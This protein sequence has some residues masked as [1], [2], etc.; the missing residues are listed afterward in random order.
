MILLQKSIL[1]YNST[2][3]KNAYSSKDVLKCASHTK[4]LFQGN[5]DSRPSDDSDSYHSTS[6][7]IQSE[8]FNAV[9]ANNSFPQGFPVLGKGRSSTVYG[10]SPKYVFKLPVRHNDLS[11]N[12]TSSKDIE[13][14]SDRYPSEYLSQP[15][16]KI[17]VKNEP[18]YLLKRV[19]GKPGS[20]D[21]TQLTYGYG[22]P[23]YLYPQCREDYK[24]FIKDVSDMPYSAYEKLIRN[25]KRLDNDGKCIDPNSNNLMIDK[26]S[27]R[28]HLVD[29]DEK[30]TAAA[31]RMYPPGKENNI[32]YIL[33]MLIDMSFLNLEKD[34]EFLDRELSGRYHH[35]QP[36]RRRRIMNNVLKAACNEN[37]IKLVDPSDLSFNPRSPLF[38]LK[39]LLKTGNLN[40]RHCNDIEDYL[41]Q[42]A[43]AT[44]LYSRRE[45]SQKIEEIFDNFS[46]SYGSGFSR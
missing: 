17:I 16:A 40:D 37:F 43:N 9:K 39:D 38:K 30:D 6:S 19:P 10:I 18:F 31:I 5:I 33:S 15:L 29:I 4:P 3:N 7:A 26:I 11:I 13:I 35:R 27:S 2:K 36:R 12:I 34:I 14:I 23:N 8:I 28:L 21:Y 44:T 42:A 20:M 24:S 1:Y 46:D 32:C 25:I 22:I 41:R 45:A